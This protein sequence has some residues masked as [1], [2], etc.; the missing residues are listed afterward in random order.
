MRADPV[1]TNATGLQKIQT[2]FNHLLLRHLGR[3]GLDEKRESPALAR[4]ETLTLIYLLHERENEFGSGG[5]PPVRGCNRKALLADLEDIDPQGGITAAS[6]LDQMIAG[7]L[8][9][10]NGEQGVELTAKAVET[11]ALYDAAFP[12]MP[13][14]SFVAYL[15]QTIQEVSSGRKTLTAALGQ[16]DRT[17]RLQGRP[18]GPEGAIVAQGETDGPADN[19][20]QTAARL[21]R[22]CRL[23]EAAAGAAPQ[24]RIVTRSGCAAQVAVKTLFPRK[25]SG[26]LDEKS[27]AA[28]PGI[29]TPETPK[30]QGAAKPV[31]LP[32]GCGPL[33]PVA[34]G[35]G[36]R[37]AGGEG[38]GR[39]LN[40]GGSG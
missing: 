2:A 38:E 13:G 22:L 3:L 23:R 29:R 32:P 27:A 6:T 26:P 8:V 21:N 35:P 18:R 34:S 25:N 33:T 37:S 11:V 10:E 15:L 40:V 17:L 7:G 28:E 5:A 24:P 16:V 9:A 31:Q 36:D 39:L 19:R 4:I 20:P 12:G 14:L 30:V 1:E